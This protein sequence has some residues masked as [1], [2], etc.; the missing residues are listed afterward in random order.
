MEEGNLKV[1]FSEIL[2]GYTLVTIPDSGEVKIKHFNNFD[3]AELDIK[4]RF[5][6]I[7]PY[8]KVF[9]QESNELI[10]Y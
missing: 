4:N 8:P 1:V 9:Q 2:R 10:T 7:K 6:T 3:A 5:F